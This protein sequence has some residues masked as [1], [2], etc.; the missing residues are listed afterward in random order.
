MSDIEWKRVPF[1]ANYLVQRDDGRYVAF[2]N[3]PVIFA[4][5]WVKQDGMHEALHFGPNEMDWR[6]TLQERPSDQLESHPNSELDADQ[7]TVGG[8]TANMPSHY[9]SGEIECID[10]IQAQMTPEQFAGYLRG[11]CVKYTGAIST[12]VARSR[13]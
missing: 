5:E 8:D 3:R 13:C 7:Y 4:D 10:A 9:T 6:D 12:R 2:E 1:W 11:N